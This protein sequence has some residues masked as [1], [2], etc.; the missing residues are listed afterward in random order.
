MN[1]IIHNAVH[2][3][4]S[5]HDCVVKMQVQFKECCVRTCLFE[6]VIVYL[7]CIQCLPRFSLSPGTAEAAQCFLDVDSDGKPDIEVCNSEKIFV[8][9]SLVAVP[10]FQIKF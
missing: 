2:Y 9:Q 5:M 3:S 4:E 8:Y 6:I 1:C 10:R 7:P